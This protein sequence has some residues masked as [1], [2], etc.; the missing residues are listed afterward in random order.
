MV[1]CMQEHVHMH[2]RL[3]KKQLCDNFRLVFPKNIWSQAK[4]TLL[5]TFFF[6]NLPHDPYLLMICAVKTTLLKSNTTG[7]HK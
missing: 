3:M 1:P 6:P 2:M 5:I 4:S 7:T